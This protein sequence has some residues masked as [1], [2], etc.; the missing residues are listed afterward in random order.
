MTGSAALVDIRHLGAA[1]TDGVLVGFATEHLYHDLIGFAGGDPNGLRVIVPD[2]VAT[3]K[4]VPTTDRPVRY[5]AHHGGAVIVLEGDDSTKLV[6]RY[7][8][9]LEALVA[10]WWDGLT[11][12]LRS[13]VKQAA[14][15][16][17]GKYNV[18]ADGIRILIDTRCPVGP[19]ATAWEVNPDFAW[20]WPESLRKF[21]L[22]QG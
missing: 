22:D 14:E 9:P 16:A 1:T 11:D 10:K 13:R 21:V 2:L 7:G 6:M 5:E 19:V 18:G 3:A 17:A 20:S 15:Q 4:H 8:V 12:D